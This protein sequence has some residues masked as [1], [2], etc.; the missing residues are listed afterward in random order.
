[1]Y[2]WQRGGKLLGVAA[3]PSP[4]DQRAEGA[5]RFLKMEGFTTR[6]CLYNIYNT[7]MC[8]LIYRI[9]SG[10]SGCSD[11]QPQG[12]QRQ[13]VPA[14]PKAMQE[15]GWF[16]PCHK[17]SSHGAV[18]SPHS[19]KLPVLVGCASPTGSQSST[20]TR[21]P[22][23]THI[24][25]GLRAASWGVEPDPYLFP[26]T[27]AWLAALVM[28]S[29]KPLTQWTSLCQCYIHTCISHRSVPLTPHLLRISCKMKSSWALIL[30][31]LDCD[32]HP[33]ASPYCLH[34]SSCSFP[35]H[36]KCIFPRSA[37]IPC[38]TCHQQGVPRGELGTLAESYCR[39]AT[40]ASD[41]SAQP[42]NLTAAHEGVPCA[43]EYTLYIFQ[44][45]KKTNNLLILKRNVLTWKWVP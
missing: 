35:S 23:P 37:R 8:I 15:S 42:V 38:R 44:H 9:I 16:T 26:F 29:Q 36:S 12:G 10:W 31:P 19:L 22:L 20:S 33:S 27:G 13:A 28:L 32:T 40:Q 24:S 17:A 34:E 25:T 6:F 39:T 18:V 41:L 4:P 43:R 1:M 3:S 7:N 21:L 2:G 14:L 30:Q 5:S 11:P 45:I